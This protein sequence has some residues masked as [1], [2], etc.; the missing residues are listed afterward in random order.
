[1]VH[2]T[3]NQLQYFH[4]LNKLPTVVCIQ[5]RSTVYTQNKKEW[6]GGGGRGRVPDHAHLCVKD[7]LNLILRHRIFTLNIIKINVYI[8]SPPERV[9]RQLHTGEVQSETLLV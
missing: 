9:D 8:F 7:A 5:S 2:C 3:H 1:M 4:V 6:G